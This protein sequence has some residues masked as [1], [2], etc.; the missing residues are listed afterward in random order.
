MD[1]CPNCGAKVYP[2]DKRC[3]KCGQELKRSSTG[4]VI[5]V[6]GIVI[7]IAIFGVFASGL[8]VSQDT[9]DVAVSNDVDTSVDSVDESTS[10]DSVEEITSSDNNQV[11]SSSQDDSSS[12]GTVYWASDDSNKFHYP[13]CE[14]AQKI[15]PYNKIVYHSRQEAINDGRRPCHVCYP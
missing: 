13:S 2:S 14:W 3:S 10:S 11:S 1:K 12:S 4:S 7:L 9:A 8:N 6:L 5:A 15:S